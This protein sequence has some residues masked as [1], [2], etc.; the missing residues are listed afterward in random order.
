ML[1]MSWMSAL[2]RWQARARLLGWLSALLRWQARARLLGW[3]SA[4]GRL[5]FVDVMAVVIVMSE[6]RRGPE[7]DRSEEPKFSGSG[8]LRINDDFLFQDDHFGAL[9]AAG[10]PAR[11]IRP[12][13]GPPRN[14][15][16]ADGAQTIV[17]PC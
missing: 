9:L 13:F 2:L 8:R 16:E 12:I 6:F 7:S 5:S 1:A 11:P 15:P 3:L 4:L 14:R 10:K 17:I